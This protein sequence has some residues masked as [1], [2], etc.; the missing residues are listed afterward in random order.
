MKR[1]PN[2]S[3]ADVYFARQFSM[4]PPNKRRQ[5]H[6]GLKSCYQPD[7]ILGKAVIGNGS[8]GLETKLFLGSYITFLWILVKLLFQSGHVQSM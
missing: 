6:L 1:I 8:H 5:S 2:D 7:L 3:F 4:Q